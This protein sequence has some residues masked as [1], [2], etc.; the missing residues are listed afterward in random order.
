VH[1]TNPAGC[2]SRYQ[3]HAEPKVSRRASASSRDGVRRKPKTKSR[4]DEQKP[5]MRRGAS[6]TSG[7]VTA[8]SSICSDGTSTGR[9]ALCKSGVYASK[10]PCLTA[11]DLSG[12]RGHRPS[13]GRRVT[14]AEYRGEVSRGRS[15]QWQGLQPKKPAEGLNGARKG[16]QERDGN[17]SGIEGIAS[18]PDEAQVHPLA[19]E[20]RLPRCAQCARGGDSIC[21]TAVYV[22]RTHGG[23]GGRGREVPS[24]PD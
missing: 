2:K 10:D 7:H 23:V 19:A 17:V 4:G 9:G 20:S 11:G 3:V 5:D 6:E 22:T 16:L 24:Y 12:A 8:K 21:R 15:R 14:G 13:A 18:D 1:G